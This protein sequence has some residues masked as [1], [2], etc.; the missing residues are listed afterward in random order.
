M[1]VVWGYRYMKE[2][3]SRR[4]GR[5]VV[6]ELSGMGEVWSEKNGLKGCDA[7]R[8]RGRECHPPKPYPDIRRPGPGNDGIA[9]RYGWIIPD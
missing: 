3:S 5:D 2:G 1:K 6:V 8:S 7:R 9:L 4:E